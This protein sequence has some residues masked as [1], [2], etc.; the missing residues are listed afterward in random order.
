LTGV[1]PLSNQPL[2]ESD[3]HDLYVPFLDDRLYLYIPERPPKSVDALRTMFRSFEAG[4]PPGSG[5]VWLNW[6]IRQ[7]AD[8]LAI[9]TLQA[10]LFADRSLWLGYK[11]RPDF[12]RRG[13]ATQAVKWLIPVLQDRFSGQQLL[14]S[15]D[16]RNIGSIRVLEKT[17]FKILRTEPAELHGERSE[18]YIFGL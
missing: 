17:G 11:I 13:F 18:D 1:P 12:W 14:A 6:T 3:A 4:P 15:V 8:R 5:E 7:A 2:R 9:G 16:I 10:T